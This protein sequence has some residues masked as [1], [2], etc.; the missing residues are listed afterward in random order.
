VEH[1]L[2]R[3]LQRD[4]T[5]RLSH[6]YSVDTGLYR[7]YYIYVIYINIY[8]YIYIFIVVLGYIVGDMFI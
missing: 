1:L 5:N 6:G 7:C 8:L 4:T 3:I 2:L